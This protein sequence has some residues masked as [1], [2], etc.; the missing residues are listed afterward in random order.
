MVTN[1]TRCIEDDCAR[2]LSVRAAWV[3]GKTTFTWLETA[4]IQKWFGITTALLPNLI[5]SSLRRSKIGCLQIWNTKG[6]GYGE[7]DGLRWWWLFVGA[8]GV[9]ETQMSLRGWDRLCRKKSNTWGEIWRCHGKLGRAHLTQ[10]G[11]KGLWPACLVWIICNLGPRD[12]YF[13]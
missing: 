1:Y 2:C 3:R 5:I 11:K 9:G 4:A 10:I 8:Y 13:Q 6:R 7:H 12:S